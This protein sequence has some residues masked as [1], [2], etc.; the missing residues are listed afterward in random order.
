MT[1]QCPVCGQ[2]MG[3][4]H[5][6][7]GPR[8]AAEP[9]WKKWLAPSGFALG[10]YIRQSVAIARFEDGAIIAAS[11]DPNAIFVGAFIWAVAQLLVFTAQLAP[12][13]LRGVPVNWSVVPINFAVLIALYGVAVLA[14]YA[15]CHALARWWFH[16]RGDFAGIV[17]AMLLG[18]IV[19]WV[20]VI[21]YVG[22]PVARI[23]SVAVLMRVFEEVDGIKRMEAFG[24]AL[25]TSVLFWVVA[26][27]FFTA[28]R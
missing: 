20:Y 10:H 26:L 7:P 2:T 13:V 15:L 22:P 4:T 14:Q 19:Q 25:G 18:S 3:L 6:C 23:W 16:A 11:R 21:P 17:N 1:S 12:L 27:L 24:L 8:P 9:D 5:S 28:K